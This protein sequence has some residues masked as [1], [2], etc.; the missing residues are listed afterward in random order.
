MQLEQ[1]T[2]MEKVPGSLEYLGQPFSLS[3]KPGALLLM[4]L[5]GTSVI[6]FLA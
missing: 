4:Q 3:L 5:V 6:K 2:Y 1:P